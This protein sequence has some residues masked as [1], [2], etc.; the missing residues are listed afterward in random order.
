MRLSSYAPGAAPD[1]PALA[2][3]AAWCRGGPRPDD[4]A[5]LVFAARTGLAGSVW[6]PIPGADDY[7]PCSREGWPHT[8]AGVVLLAADAKIRLESGGKLTDRELAALAD[9]SGGNY[10]RRLVSLGSLARGVDGRIV[11]VRR[12]L[13][14][15]GAL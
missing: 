11:D 15:R 5:A 2:V 8:A 13:E 7:G 4:P 6:R 3:L 14:R 10:V 12:V 9:W 1:H